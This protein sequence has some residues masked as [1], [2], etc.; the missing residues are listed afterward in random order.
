MP[1]L[2]DYKKAEKKLK[3]ERTKNLAEIETIN[4][5]LERLKKKV[6]E[7]KSGCTHEYEIIF[8]KDPDDLTKICTMKDINKDFPG[9]ES[10][11]KLDNKQTLL[12]YKNGKFEEI[13][14]FMNYYFIGVKCTKCGFAKI[15]DIDFDDNETSL[16]FKLKV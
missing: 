2:Q 10:K 12:V 5:K 1:T 9:I 4:K 8:V 11:L 3:E 6:E 16:A 7:L 13:N 14:S 15:F